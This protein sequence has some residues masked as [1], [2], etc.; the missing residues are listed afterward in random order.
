MKT[1]IHLLTTHLPSRS[2]LPGNGRESPIR[3]VV[4]CYFEDISANMY[5]LQAKLLEWLAYRDSFLDEL[6]RHEGFADSTGTTLCS[7]CE[8]AE[9]TI[10][11]NDC[12]CQLLRCRNCI[13][14]EH[15]NLPLHCIK[16]RQMLICVTMPLIYFAAMEWP[17]L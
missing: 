17:I 16:V 13:V 7:S 14:K 8:E 1:R 5:P 4:C 10:K 6:L 11:C 12:F 2:R 9:G 3:R 15:A